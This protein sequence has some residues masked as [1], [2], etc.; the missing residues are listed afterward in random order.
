MDDARHGHSVEVTWNAMLD[1]EKRFTATS[2]WDLMTMQELQGMKT[3]KG[4][5]YELVAGSCS[6]DSLM[7]QPMSDSVERV[8]PFL[9]ETLYDI[10]LI[11]RVVVVRAAVALHKVVCEQSD[12]HW[13][14]DESLHT[15]L[16]GIDVG[17]QPEILGVLA[18]LKSRF[19]GVHGGADLHQPS[20]KPKTLGF[21][22]GL[23]SN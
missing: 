14:T 6:L 1:W 10:F 21:Q 9:G 17:D 11:H 8:R 16:E 19:C 15:A 22:V 18:T 20:G 13:A 7:D 23:E 2:I 3:L 5:V 4:D 12:E